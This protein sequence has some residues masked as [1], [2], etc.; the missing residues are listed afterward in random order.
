MCFGEDVSPT[1]WRSFKDHFLLVKQA[2]IARGVS[3]WE[4][5]A[6][7]SVE[8]RLCLTGA[9]AEYLREEAA[10]DSDWVKNDVE[11][12][13]RLEKLYVTI[14]AIEVRVIR[15]EEAKQGLEESMADFLTRLQRLA[16]DAFASESPDVKRKRVVWRFLDGLI[17]RDVRE[18]LIRERWM[19]DE[20]NAKEYDDI[21]KIAETARTSKQAAS[22]TG[23]RHQFGGAAAVAQPQPV[24]AAAAPPLPPAPRGQRRPAAQPGS[25]PCQLTAPPAARSGQPPAGQS[26]LRSGAGRGRAVGR[27]FY[28]SIPHSGGWYRCQRRLAENPGWTPR[29]VSAAAPA[30]SAEQ[31]GEQDFC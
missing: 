12:L 11:I 7:R 18:R 10:Q 20:S 23:S 22:L 25:A 5:A 31:Q 16:S 29:R 2:N 14:E 6:Y 4:D 21:L 19:K 15:F 1:A 26:G 13:D 28:C 3:V 17:D 24:A 9:P 30:I 27:C 8:L